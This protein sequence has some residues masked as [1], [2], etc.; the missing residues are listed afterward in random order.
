MSA[1]RHEMACAVC[2]SPLNVMDG[3]YLHPMHQ[4]TDGHPP[5]PV[6]TES[7]DTIRRVCDFCGDPRPLWSITGANIAVGYRTNQANVLQ[8]MGEVWAACAACAIDI[9]AGRHHAPADRAAR[10]IGAFDPVVWAASRRL[11]ADFLAGRQPGR[12]LITTTAWPDPTLTPRDLPRVRDALARF[13]RGELGLPPT[14]TI[15]GA[16]HQLAES[17]DRAHLYWIDDAFTDMTEA[18]CAQLPA[19][20]MT[21]DLPPCDDGLLIWSHPVTPHAIIAATWTHHNDTT[22]I[23]LYRSIGAGLTD[24]PIQTLR[25]EVGWLAPIRDHRPRHG[26]LI[27]HAAKHP[28]A[29]LLSAWLLIAQGAAETETA[30]IDKTI[31]KRY[32][33]MKQPVP[34]VRIIHIRAQHRSPATA[35]QPAT[36]RPYTQRVWVTGHWRNQP[37]GPG[38]TLRRPV[39]I[40]PHLRGPEE[41][42][43][44]LSTTVRVLGNRPTQTPPN[45]STE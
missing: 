33:R 13:L 29:P 10:Q 36:A 42:K 27:N 35:T 2:L 17:L 39:Y 7:L 19:L 21:D 18:A 40:H 37:Y 8:G 26:D 31:R 32:D 28:A 14:T 30:P 1:T 12:T 3:T 45:T 16:R 44:N 6:P 5:T 43:I 20:T 4:V 24:T 11:H 34:E 9:E 38:R 23:V 22:W 25:I 41:A 15:P